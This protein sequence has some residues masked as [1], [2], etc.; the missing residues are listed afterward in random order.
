[1]SHE[2]GVGVSAVGVLGG[3]CGGFRRRA[4]MG[5]VMSQ[6]IHILPS[7]GSGAWPVKM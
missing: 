5:S 6:I 4:R 7:R 3:G 1:M 2:A